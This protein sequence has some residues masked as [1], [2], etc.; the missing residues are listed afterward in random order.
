VTRPRFALA[1]FTLARFVL[2]RFAVSC[3]TSACRFEERSP[4]SA[5]GVVAAAVGVVAGGEVDR[6]RGDSEDV[7]VVSTDVGSEGVISGAGMG[8]KAVSNAAGK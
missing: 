1:R 6:T 8:L 7:F 5:A 4:R 2:A 3:P